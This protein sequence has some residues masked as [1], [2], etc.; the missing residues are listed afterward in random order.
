MPK[1]PTAITLPRFKV[2]YGDSS[3]AGSFLAGGSSQTAS[4]GAAVIAAHR[5][6]V[7]ELLKLAGK[8]SPLH[9][10]SADEV[11]SLNGGLCKLDDPKQCESLLKE[12]KASQGHGFCEPSLQCVSTF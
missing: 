6:L 7:S 5:E 4:I 12:R 2:N 1:A 9:G 3:L 11:G 10:L 8:D